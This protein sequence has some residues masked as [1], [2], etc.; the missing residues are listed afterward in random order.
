MLLRV[1]LLTTR[2]FWQLLGGALVL[3]T[4]VSCAEYR[5][6]ELRKEESIVAIG[7]DYTLGVG[8]SAAYSYP[9]VLSNLLN[10]KVINA[11]RRGMFSVDASKALLDALQQAANEG[12]PAKLA[13]VMVGYQDLNKKTDPRYFQEGL[14]NVLS[15]SNSRKIPVILVGTNVGRNTEPHPV[16]ASLASQFP[17]VVY[18]PY[19]FMSVS[20]GSGDKN[21]SDVD[22]E[23]GADGYRQLAENLEKT[24]RKEGFLRD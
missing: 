6:P 4:L 15:L 7:D 24:I 20:K 19:A 23:M 16:Y 10:R 14:Y 11:G 22:G 9:S 21:V 12:T 13:I 18:M 1:P 3:S 5:F 17:I 2:R 8:A